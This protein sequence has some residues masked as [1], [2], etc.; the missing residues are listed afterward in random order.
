MARSW[1][2]LGTW[3]AAGTLLAAVGCSSANN[4]GEEAKA[5]SINGSNTGGKDSTSTP[6][7][8]QSKTAKNT[9]DLQHPVV[10]IDTSLGE[11]TVELDRER[12]P[13]TV[14]NFL[15][16]IEEG[17][18]DQTVFHQVLKGKAI[19]GGAYTADLV[20]K[21]PHPGVRNEALNGLK[22]VRGTIAMAR[23]ADIV[24]SATCMFFLNLADNP[25]LDHK[26]S[27][28]GAIGPPEDYGYCVFGKVTAGMEV[29]EKI[30]SLPVQD[31]NGF[32]MMPLQTV[33]IKSIR[34]V[35]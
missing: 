21:K 24:D 7:A 4:K 6:G 35:Q 22:N 3:L 2:Y 31:K 17:F 15:G 13:L 18:Y 11:I 20:G 29:V 33:L 16:Y 28:K 25:D 23:Q 14:N 10:K 5:A 1:T 19:L 8:S 26:E 9:A 27:A 12:A 32:E 34:R 30:S